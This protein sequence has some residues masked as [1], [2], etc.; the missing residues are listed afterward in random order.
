MLAAA[1]PALMVPPAIEHPLSSSSPP[2]VGVG[3]GDTPLVGD[4]V[5]DAI[6]DP[7]GTGDPEGTGD[8]VGDAVG[9]AEGP[10]VC[11]LDSVRLIATTKTAHRNAKN[12]LFLITLILLVFEITLNSSFLY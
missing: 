5:G 6:G 12:K 3:D 9:D 8:P 2:L 11:P 1:C 7:V 4:A 10:G